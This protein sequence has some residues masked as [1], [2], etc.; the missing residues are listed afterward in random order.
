MPTP[1]PE[2]TN[3]VL[4]PVLKLAGV[5]LP[6]PAAAEAREFIALYYDQVDTED[7]GK[8]APEDLYGAALSHL[9]FARRFHTG[10][11][12]LRVYNPRAEEH[13]WS[14]P[15]T[16]VEIVNDDMPF[17]VDSVSLELARQGCTVHLLVH[18]LVRTRRDPEGQLEAFAQAG[19]SGAGESYIHVEVDRETEP[20]RLKA[21]GDGLLSV[22]ADVRAAVE[23]WPAMRA[24]MEE[25]AKELARVPKGVDL[26]LIHI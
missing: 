13:G 1:A 6:A 8:R 19:K 9:A 21:L 17:L 11:P 5:R 23:D 15:H 3:A 7:L 12:K 10:T 22:L 20:A 26:S 16:V 24:R 14:S 2:A 4:D 18:P 25:I